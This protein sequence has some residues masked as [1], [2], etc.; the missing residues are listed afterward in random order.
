MSVLMQPESKGLAAVVPIG[1]ERNG[2]GA[3]DSLYEI[4]HG[5]R[6]E[7]PPMS[8][9]AIWI[10]SRLHGFLWPIVEKNKLGMAITEGMFILDVKNDI[11]RRPDVAFV[12]AQTWPLDR[13][14]PRVGDLPVAPDLAVE[15][16]SPTD[17]MDN[18]IGKIMEYFHY[19]V[20]EVWLILPMQGQVYVYTSPTQ[21]RILTARDELADTIVP[22]FRIIL[23]ELFR[24]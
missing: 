3:D 8:Y 10:A 7:L 12:S 1:A 2:I 21:V 16:N 14:I 15:V 13:P 24:S 18:V 23:A 20:R 19:G 17:L 9:L 5:L 11:R 4:V 22:G 6:V